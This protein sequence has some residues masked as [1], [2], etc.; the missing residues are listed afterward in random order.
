VNQ[1]FYVYMVV[2]GLLLAAYGTGML[3]RGRNYP[4][5]LGR[6]FTRGETQRLQR[7]PA[8]Y[9]R[10]VGALGLTAGLA[11]LDSGGL[12]GFR[13]RFSGAVVTSLQVLEALLYFGLIVCLF[14]LLRLANRY[15]LFR[16]N[17]P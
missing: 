9:F 3:L 4:P 13:S 6:G 1:S 10:A 5:P 2:L 14:W 16:W 8:I 11:F 17:K 12:T 15:K 7:A